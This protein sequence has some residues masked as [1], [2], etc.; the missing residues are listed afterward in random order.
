MVRMDYAKERDI[1]ALKAVWR[2]VFKDTNSYINNYFNYLF[3]NI[4]IAVSRDQD[5][6]PI[7]MLSMLP[8]ELKMGERRY[9]GHYI[10]AAATEPSQERKGLMT[11]LLEFACEEAKKRGEFFSCLLPETEKLFSFYEKRGYRT[12]FYREQLHLPPYGGVDEES[13]AEITSLSLS[14]FCSLR[15]TFAQAQDSVLLQPPS[16][17]SYLY[18][19]L[20]E[21]GAEMLGVKVGNLTGYAVCYPMEDLLVIKETSLTAEALKRV[22]PSLEGYFGCCGTVASFSLGS[23]GEPKPVGMLRPLKALPELTDLRGYMGL[24]MD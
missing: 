11:A 7:S 10:Y 18:A 23:G 22:C 15:M 24:F 8:V 14:T 19:E 21:S 20:K 5:G 16:L 1:P 3:N 6:R 12:A 13:P 4:R 9:V 2:S 17:Y